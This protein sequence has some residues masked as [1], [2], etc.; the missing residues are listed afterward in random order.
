M[1][2]LFFFS[3]CMATIEFLKNNTPS[4]KEKIKTKIAE[5]KQEIEQ[6]KKN[7][8]IKNAKLKNDFE[9]QRK[10]ILSKLNK[11]R[12]NKLRPFLG[13]ISPDRT[14][15]K[16]EEIPKIPKFEYENANSETLGNYIKKNAL[17][18]TRDEKI[19]DLYDDL[20]EFDE[21][22]YNTDN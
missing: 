7:S 1:N 14:F 12:V 9:K 5:L 18:K 3:L 17:E 21:D 8:E 16:K 6:T 4:N 19:G 15:I 13:Q 22:F 10:N 11:K 20:E 2:Y